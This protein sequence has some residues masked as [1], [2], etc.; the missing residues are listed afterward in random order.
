MQRTA[1]P[2]F[3]S[4]SRYIH[5]ILGKSARFFASLRPRTGALLMGRVPSFALVRI[6]AGRPLAGSVRHARGWRAQTGVTP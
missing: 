2:L 6:S 5:G 4:V 1:N 3:S